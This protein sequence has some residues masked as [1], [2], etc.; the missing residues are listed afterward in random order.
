MAWNRYILLGEKLPFPRDIQRKCHARLPYALY[1]RRSSTTPC[2]TEIFSPIFHKGP[3]LVQAD[4]TKSQRDPSLCQVEVSCLAA[5][6]HKE[7]LLT[8]ICWGVKRYQNLSRPTCHYHRRVISPTAAFLAEIPLQ[9]HLED[10]WLWGSWSSVRPR[11]PSLGWDTGLEVLH[12]RLVLSTKRKKN[13]KSG[14][15]IILVFPKDQSFLRKWTHAMQF[16]NIKTFAF[17]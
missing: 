3:R 4:L 10:S 7:F 11:Q 2:I 9:R 13:E 17:L 8:C 5:S 12:S 14:N 6:P 1:Q 15:G 16:Q